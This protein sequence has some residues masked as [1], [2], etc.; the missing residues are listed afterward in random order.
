[1]KKRN[2]FT[3]IELLVVIAIIAILAGMLLP[4]LTIAREKGRAI[5]CA[6]NLKQIGTGYYGYMDDNNGYLHPMYG[7]AAAGSTPYWNHALLG[8]N[9]NWGEHNP[10]AYINVK[11]LFCP[12]LPYRAVHESGTDMWMFWPSYGV[13]H[14]LI[15]YSATSSTASEFTSGRATKIQSPSIKFFIS[16]TDNY[17][18]DGTIESD[19]GFWRWANSVGVNWGGPS[20]RHTGACNMLFLD[21]HVAPVRPANTLRTVDFAPF[22]WGDVAGSQ[23][24]IDVLDKRW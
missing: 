11:S 6:S 7:G 18:A 13:N 8:W 23:K 3:L 12:S 4:S 9:N 1:M 2:A 14:F 10:K 19:R 17:A 21:A 20:R 24:Y 22:K 15:T 16:D 5:S